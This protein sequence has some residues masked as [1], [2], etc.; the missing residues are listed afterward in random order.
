MREITSCISVCI[1]LI[2]MQT[3]VFSQ[4]NL[5]SG[6]LVFKQIRGGKTYPNDTIW[7]APGIIKD[8][9]N[10]HDLIK[11][12]N[13]WIFGTDT[14]VVF[15]KT[16]EKEVSAEYKKIKTTLYPKDTASFAG[17]K[18]Q[19]AIMKTLDKDSNSFVWTVYYN[20]KVGSKKSNY[21]RVFK[22]IDGIPL[23]FSV[24]DWTYELIEF[25]EV[26]KEDINIPQIV[27][28]YKPKKKD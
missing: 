25:V 20:P 26:K 23:Y 24:D 2:S 5:T 17:I 27:V 10:F 13:Y 7:Y 1:L 9:A 22:D 28:K 12:K 14:Q 15:N 6:R 18:C 3:N 21:Y 11:N 8:R 16:L 4:S 19:K